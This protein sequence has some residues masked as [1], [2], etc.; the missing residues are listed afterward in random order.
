MA[1]EPK[2]FVARHDLH[3]FTAWPGALWWT[4]G[5]E[6]PRPLKKMQVGDKWIAFAYTDEVRQEPVHQVVG[7]Y[8]C[9]KIPSQRIPIPP[10]ARELVRSRYAWAILGQSLRKPLASPVTVPSIN[11]MLGRKTFGNQT[12]MPISAADFRKIQ[13]VVQN[14]AMDPAKIPLLERDP[15]NEQEVIGILVSAHKRL[16]IQK[17][18]R[19]RSRFPDLLVTLVGKC[20]PV[21]LEVETLS[22]SFIRHGHDEQVCRRRLISEDATE[23]LPVAVACWYH[24]DKTREVAKHVHKVFEIR[25]LLQKGQKMR[26]GR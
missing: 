17:I 3:S 16:G 9:I 1:R 18:E 19:M 23:R 2:Y 22:S 20:D 4:H 8:E 25:E 6:F 26:W 13:H 11:T 14:R 24:D 10:R 12:L 5:K 21:H 15:K 7:F